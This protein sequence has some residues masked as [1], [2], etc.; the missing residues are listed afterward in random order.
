MVG[1]KY[2][3]KANV[4]HHAGIDSDETAHDTHLDLLIERAS[5]MIDDNVVGRYRSVPI[6]DTETK[7]DSIIRACEWLAAGLYHIAKSG[8]KNQQSTDTQHTTGKTMVRQA[9]SDLENWAKT[10]YQN[11]QKSWAGPMTQPHQVNQPRI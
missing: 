1:E 3:D 8:R 2:C 5:R 7:E 11:A 9:L 6:P 4:K 10:F